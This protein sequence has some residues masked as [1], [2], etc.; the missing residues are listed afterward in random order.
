LVIELRLISG[1]AKINSR[2]GNHLRYVSCY[3]I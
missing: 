1:K 3:S 2:R